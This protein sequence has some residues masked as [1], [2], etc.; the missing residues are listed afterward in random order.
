MR[1]NYHYRPRTYWPGVW[2]TELS[3]TLAS[4]DRW[5]KQGL[6]PNSAPLLGA[7]PA[8]LDAGRYLP[9]MGQDEVEIA[10]VELAST[11]GDVTSIR[12]RLGAD[13]RIHYRVVDE[14]DYWPFRV[15]PEW[16]LLPLSLDELIDLIDGVRWLPGEENGEQFGLTTVFQGNLL[17][18]GGS[19]EQAVGF[20]RVGSDYYPGLTRHYELEAERWGDSMLGP[21]LQDLLELED[22]SLSREVERR[23]VPPVSPFE[24]AP[25]L[26]VGSLRDVDHARIGR[27]LRLVESYTDASLRWRLGRNAHW[28]RPKTPNVFEVEV[29]PP[30]GEALKFRWES[31]IDAP[32]TALPTVLECFAEI[33]SPTKRLDSASAVRRIVE[34]SQQPRFSDPGA[35][36]ELGDDA[37]A[38]GERPLA[39]EC[40][41]RAYEEFPRQTTV[42][43]AAYFAGTGQFDKAAELCLAA[44][45]SAL[46]VSKR[47]RDNGWPTDVLDP[48]HLYA[49]TL[50]REG[51]RDAAFKLLKEYAR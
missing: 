36:I 34:V 25:H 35:L 49:V 1:I 13:H 28:G 42:A 21:E 5:F 40:Y 19:V 27:W 3:T 23:S 17:E 24:F 39:E 4:T 41:R 29:T 51:R 33:A 12:A 43:V 47:H 14:Y 44:L 10:R 30:G 31:A 38:I 50:A 15:T 20:V 9:E 6:A 16:S 11:L 26:H 8:S 7:S 45:N 2:T 22:A 48:V 32:D 46:K 18:D 37:W